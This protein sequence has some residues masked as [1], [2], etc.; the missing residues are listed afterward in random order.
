MRLGKSPHSIGRQEQSEW[1]GL[2]PSGSHAI[3]V[4]LVMFGEFADSCFAED[5]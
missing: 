1:G 4:M 2:L 5:V 3:G